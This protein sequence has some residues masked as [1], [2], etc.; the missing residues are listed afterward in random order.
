MSC[1][2]S[3]TSSITGDC[4]N[5]NLG[6]FTIDIS[7]EAPDY[8]IQWLSPTSGTTSLGVGV[9]AYTQTN[10]SA[11]TYSFN[12][13]DSCIPSN[14]VLPVNIYISSGTCVS[15]TDVKNTIC[16]ANNGSLTATT[17][18]SY[19][20]SIFSLYNEIT[21]LISTQYPGGN[22]Y[23]FNNL[24]SGTYYAIADDGG[25]CTG[26]S[27][28]VIIKNSSNLSFGLYKINDAGCAVN[29][30]KLFITGLTGTPPYTYLWSNG[31]TNDSIS[32][33]SSGTYSVTV[34]DSSKCSISNTEV[35]TSVPQVGLGALYLTQPSCFTADGSVEIIITGGTPP[36]YYLGSNGVTNVT[37]D[38]NVTFTG[39][40]PGSFTIQ[41]TDAG[42]CNFTTSTK[43]LTPRGMS[44]VS[45]GITNSKCNDFSGVIGPINVFGGT[46]PYTYSLTNSV[47]NINSE[48]IYSTTWSFDGLS[49]DTYTLSITDNG[50]CTFT[51][52]YTIDNQVLFGL[53]VSTTGTTCNGNDGSVYLEI[54]SGGTPPYI[55]QINGSVIT[56][57]LTSYTFNNLVSGN[58][59]AS[60][61]DST[62][63]KQSKPF[64]IDGSNTV[65]FHLLGVDS[66]NNDGSISAYITNGEPPFT[67]YWSGDSSVVSGQTGMTITDLLSGEY[68]LRVVDNNGCS[69]RKRLPIRGTT[70]YASTGVY[71]ICSTSILDQP[72]MIQ[73]RPKQL[74]NEGYNQL[75]SSS[76]GYTNCILT[77]STFQ[78]LVYVGNDSASSVFF[79]GSTLLD[80]PSDEL[81]YNTIES[82]LE[83]LPQIGNVDINP[84]TNTIVVTTNCDQSSLVNAELK[85]VLRIDLDIAC[86]TGCLTPTPTKTPTMTPTKTPTPTV[87]RTPGM[88]PSATPTHTPTP[89]KTPTMT[90]TQTPT[91]SMTPTPTPTTK[92]LYYAY[93]QCGSILPR[94]FVII[95]SIPA[96]PGNMIGD[97]VLDNINKICWE[98]I[99]I[100]D[101]ENQLISIYPN[102]STYTNYFVDVTYFQ[103]NGVEKPCDNCEKSLDEPVIQRCN[104]TLT[105]IKNCA[106][107]A[108]S[109]MVYVNGILVYQF[110]VNF[111]VSTFT[112]LIPVVVG[113]VITI[114]INATGV[115]TGVVQVSDTDVNGDVLDYTSS[116]ITNDSLEYT[117]RTY[118]GLKKEIN[119]FSSCEIPCFPQMIYNGEKSINLPL[120]NSSSFKPDGTILYIV[121]HN[122][123]PSDG[124]CAY[125]LSEPWDVSTVTLPRIGCSIASPVSPSTL[126]GHYFS[127][128]GT[129]IFLC[130]GAGSSVINYTLSIHWDV[131]TTVYS[132][133]NTFNTG[134]G[135]QPNFISFTPDG[136]NMFIS[137]QSTL[138]KKYTLSTPWVINTG[139]TET[140]SI[141][142][143]NAF[144]F[145]FQN[146]GY[147]LFSMVFISGALNIRKQVLSTPYD[148]TSIVSTQTKN[149][150]SF[151]IGGNFWSIDFKD[152]FK[153]F[154][155]GYYS[156][157]LEGITAFELTCEYDISGELIITS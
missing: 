24:P 61:T 145:I 115:G 108:T 118:C 156:S 11:G 72:I 46:S 98:L 45:V 131:T 9:T 130:N 37:F 32:G 44:T 75:I 56:T 136:L 73:T 41:V 113:D 10:L 149:V 26:K 43:L 141:S 117:Y 13:I 90:P 153:G 34:T 33:L 25:G 77:A 157:T 62:F 55:Y 120:H 95:Q 85:V 112:Q 106:E 42:L 23:V 142:F 91:N 114:I 92:T 94:A 122:G 121:L 4:N 148:L 49:A 81:W 54:T 147:Y 28:N 82:L 69:K 60:V 5:T 3:Y 107:A 126:N 103:D 66:I 14:T 76:P 87:T 143:G 29:S 74:L 80:Y 30:G 123:S 19:G 144:E 68:S 63:C 150:S 22:S 35:I 53:T 38:R 105:N 52:A 79:T 134:V 137:F 119:I 110:G 36:F 151:I 128:D 127:P 83:S 124:V 84:L 65:D 31:S 67:L 50:G 17:S 152:G 71:T 48:T 6:A 154:I 39:L 138:L 93:A 86:A 1:F 146:N 15:I 104:L 20:N 132:S 40:G 139:V 2:L 135:T 12:I 97:V 111:P 7:G 99:N 27:E 96:I 18:N 51:S 57:T 140:Q 47:G 8:T 125:S 155:G 59:T 64:T 78:A 133:G 102:N 89:T 16:D 70:E 116:V 100:S 58:Y 21:G 129:K 109:G 88:S 101:N